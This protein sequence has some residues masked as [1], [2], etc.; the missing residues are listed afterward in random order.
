MN[1]IRLLSRLS[2]LSTLLLLGACDAPIPGGLTQSGGSEP[3]LVNLD[4]TDPFVIGVQ[5]ETTVRGPNKGG[6]ERGG[7]TGSFVGVG[8]PMCVILDPENVWDLDITVT[9]DGDMD[10]FVGRAADYSG[11]P[12]VVLG[13]FFGEFIDSLGIPHKLDQ[14]LCLQTDVFGGGGAHAGQG[15]AEFCTVQT[16]AGTPYIVLGETFSVPTDDDQLTVAVRVDVG[17]CPAVD[18]DTLSADN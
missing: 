9:D 16:D 7:L 12:G 15:T 6:G 5:S 8:G 17:G 11:T 3:L 18:E 2:A 4:E 1:R 10:L 13:D 14:N